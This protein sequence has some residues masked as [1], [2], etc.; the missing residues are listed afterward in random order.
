[1]GRIKDARIIRW[2]ACKW[3]FSKSQPWAGEGPHRATDDAPHF[4]FHSENRL[5][6][7]HDIL[8]TDSRRSLDGGDAFG[9]ASVAIKLPD[10]GWRFHVHTD[11]V[12]LAL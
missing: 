4:S 9:M 8:G 6:V 1:V 10:V 5:G 3:V 7:S 11:S 2:C 12:S